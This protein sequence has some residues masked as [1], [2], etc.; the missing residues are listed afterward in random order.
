MT[1]LKHVLI[2]C[3]LFVAVSLLVETAVCVTVPG[4]R[5][6][7]DV[8][9]DTEKKMLFGEE[10]IVYVSG[11]DEPLEEIYM[12]LYAN[13]YRERTSTAASETEDKLRDFTVAHSARED[14]GYIDIESL[15]VNSETVK[16]DIDDTSPRIELSAPL[17]L[18]DSAYIEISFV[19]KI[20]KIRHRLCYKD[21]NFAV[22]QWYPKMAVYDDEGWHTDKYHLLG[23]FFG[24][25]A[26][27]DVSVTLPQEFYVGAPGYLVDAVNGDNE[28]PHISET[29]N[30]IFADRLLRT[31]NI[32]YSCVTLITR[33]S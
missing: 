8:T 4:V 9:L 24:E 27:F 5:S 12:H 15:R 21:R 11:A 20:P 28:I 18:G 3:C 13:A 29:K 14:L 10:T 31:S 1:S 30:S 23:E 22:A 16:F 25:F 26:S 17:P 7:I 32:K 19:T 33:Q 2:S 6:D